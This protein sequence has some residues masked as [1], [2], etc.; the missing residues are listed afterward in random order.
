MD[1]KLFDSLIKSCQQALAYEKGDKTMGNSVTVTI[2]DE[3][4]SLNYGKS[5]DLG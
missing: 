2:P 3:E 1:K 4:I 5:E